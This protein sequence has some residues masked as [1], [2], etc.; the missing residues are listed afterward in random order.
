M[1]VAIPRPKLRRS[2]AHPFDNRGMAIRTGANTAMIHTAIILFW[3]SFCFPAS[4]ETTDENRPLGRVALAV[5]GENEESAFHGDSV[6]GPGKH[7]V[8]YAEA[9]SPCFMLVAAFTTKEGK[10]PYGWRPAIVQLPEWSERELPDPSMAWTW[11]AAAEP[12]EFYVLFLSSTAHEMLDILR[13]VSLLNEPDNEPRLLQLQTSKLRELID[14]LIADRAPSLGAPP[15]KDV[16][17]VF[18][19]GTF[20]WRDFHRSAN[21]SAARPGIIIYSWPTRR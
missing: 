6:P 14:Q 20:P 16:T 8:A 3:L 5:V 11:P 2:T 4:G 17:A 9:S 18:R 1:A 10:L 21:F 15:Q 7:I 13:L 12:F 19:N